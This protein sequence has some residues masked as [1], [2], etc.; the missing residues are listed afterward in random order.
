MG[1]ERRVLIVDADPKVVAFVSRLLEEHGCKITGARSIVDGLRRAGEETYSLIVVAI[2]AAYLDGLDQLHRLAECQPQ[3]VVAVMVKG[4]IPDLRSKVAPLEA[5]SLW[6]RQLELLLTAL[7]VD[8]G[9]AAQALPTN[10]YITREEL[11]DFAVKVD[12][13]RL[14]LMRL[15]LDYQRLMHDE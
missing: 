3:A 4:E 11:E 14:K 8:P 9:G 13:F 15:L 1:E 6:E 12:L 5:T 10:R 2:Q 7:G